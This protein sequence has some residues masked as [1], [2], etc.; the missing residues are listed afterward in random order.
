MST[1]FW[2]GL[3]PFQ[4]EQLHAMRGQIVHDHHIVGLQAKHQALLHPGQK[5]LAIHRPAKQ[6]RSLRPLEP[7]GGDHRG[8]RVMPVRDRTGQPLTDGTA[9]VAAGHLR[10]GPA[11]IHEHQPVGGHVGQPLRPFFSLFGH[12]GTRLLGGV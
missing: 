11:F 3:F 5:Q 2:I 4:V 12:V 7:H 1:L 10:I 9:P 8:R 6:P